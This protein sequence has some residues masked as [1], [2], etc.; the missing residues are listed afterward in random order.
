M[1]FDELYRI[2]NNFQKKTENEDF[3]IVLNFLLFL[4]LN[5]FAYNLCKHGLFSLKFNQLAWFGVLDPIKK[6]LK[7]NA[8]MKIFLLFSIFS[9]VFIVYV[10]NFQNYN[11][12]SMKVVQ[13][14]KFHVPV[15]LQKKKKNENMKNLDFKSN[16]EFFY[17]S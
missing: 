14:M 12:I 6:E 10:Y 8:K 13:Y 9:I 5:F 7:K 17:C 4:F 11:P 15:R 2:K 3:S 16:Y 1:R